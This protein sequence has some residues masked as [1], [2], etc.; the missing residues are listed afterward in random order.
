[1]L[2]VNQVTGFLEVQFLGTEGSYEVDVGRHSEKH[3]IDLYISTGRV[4][5]RSGIP[6][7]P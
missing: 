4:Q 5:V 7:V 2:L 3:Q 1:M 6:I